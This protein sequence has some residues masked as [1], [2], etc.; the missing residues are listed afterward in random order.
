MPAVR[1]FLGAV[2]AALV[3]IG[4]V[5]APPPAVAQNAD[6]TLRLVS[7]SPWSS[8]DFRGALDLQVAITNGGSTALRHLDLQVAFGSHLSTQADFDTML[9]S[10]APTPLA[11]SPPK[12]INGVIEAETTRTIPMTV[13]LTAIGA[14]DQVDSQVYPASIDTPRRREHRR[15]PRHSGDLSRAAARQADAV[16]G[17]GAPA[18]ADRLRRG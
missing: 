2:A 12:S 10:G 1:R 11:F 14:I 4:L 3:A 18:G 9:S 8:E 17:G 7:Q 15:D 16:H 5:A 6:V 13:D